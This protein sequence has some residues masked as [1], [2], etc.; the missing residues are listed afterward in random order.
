MDHSA[1]VDHSD[2]IPTGPKSKERVSGKGH[3][4]KRLFNADILIW[5]YQ[6]FLSLLAPMLLNILVAI[7]EAGGYEFYSFNYLHFFKNEE[8]IYLFVSVSAVTLHS[9]KK[10]RFVLFMYIPIIIA[11]V[12]IHVVLVTEYLGKDFDSTKLI[13]YC[14]LVFLVLN[15]VSLSCATFLEEEKA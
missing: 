3:F 7:K 10:L 11:G 8:L 2:L 9:L 14:F 12:V 13:S 5:S 1:E 6:L 15:I 4:F